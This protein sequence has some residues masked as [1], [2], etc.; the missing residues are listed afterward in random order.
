MQ[1][2]T[3]VLVFGGCSFTHPSA[4]QE[5]M[6]SELQWRPTGLSRLTA[7][8]GSVPYCPVMQW[9]V[10]ASLLCPQVWSRNAQGMSRGPPIQQLW[11]GSLAPNFWRH[12][13]KPY[14]YVWQGLSFSP[15]GLW[16][17]RWWQKASQRV[18]QDFIPGDSAAAQLFHGRRVK[19]GPNYWQW[20]QF[21]QTKQCC[22]CWRLSSSYRYLQGCRGWR[23]NPQN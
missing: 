12:G 11:L 13:V 5:K 17:L 15:C 10:P 9:C 3:S 1:S 16:F 14:Q 22:S 7:A 4:L 8:A 18:T 20:V 6:W 23:E 19:A 21:P 2:K